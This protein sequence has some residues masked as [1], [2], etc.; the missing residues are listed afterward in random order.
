MHITHN[1]TNVIT[2]SSINIGHFLQHS[3][4]LFLSFSSLQ[5]RLLIIVASAIYAINVSSS[6]LPLFC[7]L[8]LSSLAT[9][10]PLHCR[11]LHCI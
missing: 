4:F 10:L 1:T 11:F 3:R 5:P 9:V 6:T 7:F 8:S 2:T